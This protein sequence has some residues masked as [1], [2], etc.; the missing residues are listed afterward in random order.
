MKIAASE[1]L[2][3]NIK[4][5]MCLQI[6]S[7]GRWSC[8]LNEI[9]KRPVKDGKSRGQDLWRNEQPRV[10]SW[11]PL[12]PFSKLEGMILESHQVTCQDV[13][14][15]GELVRAEIESWIGAARVVDL[16]LPA[17]C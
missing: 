12:F 5:L 17:L 4:M 9:V 11:E 7:S 14:D 6:A 2:P 13:M 10:G 8:S 1:I 3:D 16:L 15:G